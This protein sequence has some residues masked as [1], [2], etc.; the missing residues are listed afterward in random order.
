MSGISSAITVQGRG[1]RGSTARSASLSVP[2]GLPPADLVA[3]LDLVTPLGPSRPSEPNRGMACV[4]GHANAVTSRGHGT[5]DWLLE[6]EPEQLGEPDCGP[7]G[8]GVQD[9][10][11]ADLL[12]SGDIGLDVVDEDALDWLQAERLGGV[13]EDP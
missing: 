13:P 1:G 8:V 12:G 3:P 6:I 2:E 10:G 11:E 4:A 7:A 9:A 5:D